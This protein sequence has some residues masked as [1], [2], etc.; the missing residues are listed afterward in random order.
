MPWRV[1]YSRA[2]RGGVA[3]AGSRAL[4]V[5]KTDCEDVAVDNA[6]CELLR[7]GMVVCRRS[8]WALW[9]LGRMRESI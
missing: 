6:Q 7:G 2:S 5:D 8:K 9:D 3:G 4:G 1:A